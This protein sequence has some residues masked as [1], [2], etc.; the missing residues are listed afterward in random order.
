MLTTNILCQIYSAFYH[1]SR[2]SFDLTSFRYISVQN[3]EDTHIGPLKEIPLKS[4]P[5]VEECFVMTPRLKSGKDLQGVQ[6]ALCPASR[7]MVST[8][9]TENL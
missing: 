5:I 1:Q 8:P 6:C 9:R 7:D 3:T 4:R 2:G